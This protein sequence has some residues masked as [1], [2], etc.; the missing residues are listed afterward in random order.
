MQNNDKKHGPKPAQP[1]ASPD[2][3][4]TA[5]AQLATLRLNCRRAFISFFDRQHQYIVAEATKTLSL[6]RDSAFGA[7]DGLKYGV[8][9]VPRKGSLCEHTVAVPIDLDLHDKDVSVF[10]VPDCTKD[11]RF[12]DCHYTKHSNFRFYAGVA[13]V[14]PDGYRIGSYCVVDDK[15]RKGISDEERAFMKDMATTVR[16]AP[17]FQPTH[18]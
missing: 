16:D 9:I 7:G 6:E 1:R 8:T 15:P 17:A 3:A 14:S 10:V 5:F 4:L 11:D 2:R 13:I 18:H 12:K